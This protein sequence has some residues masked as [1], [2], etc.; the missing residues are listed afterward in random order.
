MLTV[1]CLYMLILFMQ[2]ASSDVRKHFVGILRGHARHD[3]W[4]NSALIELLMTT[5]TCICIIVEKSAT[6]ICSG[7]SATDVELTDEELM[8]HLGNMCLDQPTSRLLKRQSLPAMKLHSAGVPVSTKSARGQPKG[9][10]Q[11][12]RNDVIMNVNQP[13]TFLQSPPA[14]DKG[15]RTASISAVQISLPVASTPTTS[16]ASST[17]T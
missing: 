9:T 5:C 7:I 12:Q 8:N 1:L 10:S 14:T 3:I 16:T 17:D 6:R 4:Y 11:S 15:S 13:K 2:C